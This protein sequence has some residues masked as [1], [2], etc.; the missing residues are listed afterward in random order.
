MS[1]AT[2]PLIH[3]DSTEIQLHT[4]RLSFTSITLPSLFVPGHHKL[5]T[6]EAAALTDCCFRR[7]V[8]IF[9]L[10]SVLW[11]CWLAVRKS[12]RPVKISVMVIWR[13]YLSAARCKGFALQ[14]SWCYCHHIISCLIKI[15][16]GLTFPLSA[17]PGCC[18]KE[19]VKQFCLSFIC[20]SLWQLSARYSSDGH[21]YAWHTDMNCLLQ[22]CSN[23][24]RLHDTTSCQTCCQTGL[25]AG[26]TNG[27]IV[28]Q[29][30]LLHSVCSTARRTNEM[31]QQT[32][33]N[34]TMYF[35]RRHKIVKVVVQTHN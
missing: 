1:D 14:S 25:T 28:H 23:T 3:L 26:L 4:T 16:I 21:A 31:V 11:H 18:G 13:G 27:W 32:L 19:A 8:Q 35:K 24:A 10:T 7:C 6:F 5:K 30:K 9:L 20:T 2:W 33:T 17:Y 15:Q 22:R 29:E 12:I 34:W